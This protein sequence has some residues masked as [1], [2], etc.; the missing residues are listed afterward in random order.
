M[1]ILLQ[2]LILGAFIAG[3]VALYKF[4]VSRAGGNPWY[5]WG[6]RVTLIG[7][8]L[9]FWVNG[10]VGIIGHADNDAN[11]LYGVVFVVGALIAG[12]TRFRAMGMVAA[13]GGMA[14]AQA[15][16]PAIAVAAQVDLTT[17]W[18]A[19]MVWLTAFWCAIWAG[20][21]LLFRRAGALELRADV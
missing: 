5:V 7:A 11:M 12:I 4:L 17:H 1:D 20:G 16:V 13:L 9:L 15:L 19:D 2:F 14:V 18:S 10:A 8:F 6:V 21:A 3:V